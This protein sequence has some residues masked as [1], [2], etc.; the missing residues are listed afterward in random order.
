MNIDSGAI[1]RMPTSLFR[2]PVLL[3]GLV[4]LAACGGAGSEQGK[5]AADGL[6]GRILAD[7]SSTVYP[8]SEAVAEEFMTENGGGVQ[9]TVA[10]S[11]TGGG[12]KRFCSGE[13]DIANASRPIKDEERQACAQ[14]G[15]EFVELQVAMDGLA[16]VVNP[17]N[18]FAQ[19]LT[20]D[21][22]KKIWQ[23]ESSVRT[24]A[25]VRAGFP[26]T[27]IKLYGPGTNSGTFDYFTE[28]VVGTEDASRSDYTASEDDNVLVQGVA[29]DAGSLGYFGYAYFGE[30]RQ[31]LR[32]VQVD[33]G[34]GCVEPNPQ[35]IEG[36]Q[37]A[38]LSRPLLIYV[39]K[40]SL[41]RPEV[42][43]FVEFYLASAPEL[44]S[45]VGYVPL[46]AAGYQQS[47]RTLQ[48]ATASGT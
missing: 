22:L 36:G 44:A 23:P 37:Y 42:R 19:C 6:S 5:G 13:T 27:P 34:N 38:P 46:S 41:A 25:D 4:A 29:G 10:T 17:A 40:A 43:S 31:T 11:G 32:A 45:Q 16:V 39:K 1:Q 7:G 26:A 28:E 14:A 18:T 47:T 35:T 9:V 48:Q 24:W 2:S 12:F 33:G 15:V 8:L 3:A 21:E 30:N 20:V